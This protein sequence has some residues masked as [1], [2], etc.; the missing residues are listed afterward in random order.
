MYIYIYFFSIS[1]KI[2]HYM[3][4]LCFHDNVWPQM[5]LK[6]PCSAPQHLSNRQ[7]LPAWNSE[8]K[9][10]FRFSLILRSGDLG[11]GIPWG[12]WEMHQ[13][14][15][16]KWKRCHWNLHR[17]LESLTT[18]I[19]MYVCMYVYIYIYIC[20]CVWSI[21]IMISKY[22]SLYIIYIYIYISK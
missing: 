15:P 1:Y 16:I 7:R 19:H 8:A 5:V 3:C 9:V 10:V 21:D 6:L 14:S 20:V 11:H 22:I 13:L 17:I 4:I 2:Y 12:P 18:C